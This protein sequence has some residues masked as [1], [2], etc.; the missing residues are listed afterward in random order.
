MLYNR[1]IKPV[2]KDSDQAEREIVLNYLLAGIFILAI[3]ALVD[4]VLAPVISREPAHLDRIVNNSVTVLFIGGLYA[5]A[6]Y[7]QQYKTVAVTLTLLIAMFACSMV[8]SWGLLVPTGILLCSVAIIMAGILISARSALYVAG[9]ITLVVIGLQYAKV[10]GWIHPDLSWMHNSSTAGDVIG[11]SSIFFVIAF[12]SWLFNRQMELSLV[13]AQ[14]SE[15]ALKRQRDVLEIKVEKRARQLEAA[16]LE[17]MQELYRFAELGQLST[18]LFHDLANHLSTVNLDIEGLPIDEAPDIM[19]RIQQNVGDINSIV[20]RVRHQI[21]GK[22]TIEVFDVMHEIKEVVKILEPAATQSGVV[23]RVSADASVKP[24]LAYKGDVTRFRQIVLN[25][26]SN[27]IEAYPARRSSAKNSATDRIV[28]VQ[29][30]RQRST[31]FIEVNDR[32]RGIRASSLTKIFEPFYTTKSKG[33]GI[34]LFIVRQVVEHDFEGSINVTSE[35]RRGTTF[36]IGLPKSY[37]VRKPGR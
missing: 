1:F 9:A 4:T 13:R 18:A 29:L 8:Y 35:K 6:R 36:S 24:S 19:R 34:G 16:Q 26:I 22:N 7:K 3:I 30:R 33:V 21:S 5:L 27:G 14:R 15:K 31:L 10:R 23:V 20:R 28:Y 32:G 25:L 17:K 2:S 37:Y 11:F 12:V